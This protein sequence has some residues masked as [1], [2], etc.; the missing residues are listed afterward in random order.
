MFSTVFK[1][2]DI[3][4]EDADIANTARN[5]TTNTHQTV[6]GYTGAIIYLTPSLNFDEIDNQPDA[7]RI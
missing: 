1:V 7:W 4:F 6:I 5:L 2:V 3:D